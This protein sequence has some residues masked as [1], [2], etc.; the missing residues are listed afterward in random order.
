MPSKFRE[1]FATLYKQAAKLRQATAADALL[2]VLDSTTDWAALRKAGRHHL[3]LC[4][5]QVAKYLEGA[6]EHG[7]T[8]VLLEADDIPVQELMETA[9]LDCVAN[10][11]LEAGSQVVAVYSGFH[12]DMHDSI[13]LIRLDEHLGKL[14]AKDLRK[15]ETRVPLETLKSVVDLAVEIGFEGREGKPVGTL[16]VV[17]DARNVLEYCKPAGFDPVRGYKKDDRNLKDARTRDAVKEI[18]LLDGAMIISSDGVIERS[19]QIIQ[20]NATSLTLSKGLGARHWAAASI[21]KVTKAISVVVSESNGTVRLFQ[22]GQVVLRIEPMRRAMKW[23]E[24]DFD[25]PI[26]S[27]E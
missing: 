17:G 5:A 8:P 25:P 10:D 6:E 27:S 22:D 18:A 1:P 12:S 7:L 4:V 20:V 19:C 3:I 16:F 11:V 9:L 15:L 14:T 23:R 2:L 13:S 24:F 26:P 21:S